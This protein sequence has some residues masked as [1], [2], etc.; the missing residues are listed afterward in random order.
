MQQL[1]AFRCPYRRVG[2]PIASETDVGICPAPC[3]Y[4]V[5]VLGNQTIDLL[6]RRSG[7]LVVPV[8]RVGGLYLVVPFIN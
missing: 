3:L 8:V 5:A 6:D 7:G 2:A 1:G 4:L